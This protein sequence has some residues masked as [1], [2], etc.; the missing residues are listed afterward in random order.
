MED[1][2]GVCDGRKKLNFFQLHSVVAQ[3]VEYEYILVVIQKTI[4]ELS[5]FFL[6]IAY[7]VRVQRSG[8]ACHSAIS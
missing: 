1:V 5:V 4:N 7:L 3:I 8:R 6:K 2:S